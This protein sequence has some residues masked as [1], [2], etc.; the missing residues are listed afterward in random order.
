MA[1]NPICFSPLNFYDDKAKQC[2]RR[3]FAYGNISPLIVRRGFFPCFQ[4]VIPSE[5][6]GQGEPL[7]EAYVYDAATDTP[8][9]GDISENLTDTGF[10]ISEVN[11]YNVA[12]YDGLLPVSFNEEGLYYL[13]LRGGTAWRYYSEVFCPKGNVNDC[14]EI[15]YWNRGGGNFYVKNG[16]IAFPDNF[17]FRLLLQT[18]LG[19][20]EYNFEEESSKRMGYSFIESQTSKKVYKFNVLAPE[21]ICDAMRIIRLCSDKIIKTGL[22]EHEALTFEME[23]DWQTQGDLASV[24]C[25]FEV[26]NVIANF[27]GFVSPLLGGDF[28]GDYNNDFNTNNEQ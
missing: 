15:E 5:Q 26:D 22:Y 14:I 10:T 17:H 25:E 20:P 6:Y 19:K 11:G 23:T 24:S 13:E 1:I 9:T 27:G 28:N 12:L 4:F 18:E 2:H 16:I 21:F 8:V 7:T 3:S